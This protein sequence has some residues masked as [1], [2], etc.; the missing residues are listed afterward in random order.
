MAIQCEDAVI[1][2]YER[3]FE[4]GLPGRRRNLEK[5]EER[6]TMG[7][8]KKG[9]GEVEMVNDGVPWKVLLGYIWVICWFWFSLGW[10][11]DAN[12]KSGLFTIKAAKISIVRP[13]LR[14]E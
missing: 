2:G 13:L 5:E 12:L 8:K 14:L 11:G 6:R 1:G 4:K 3:I 9:G 10:G 7:E